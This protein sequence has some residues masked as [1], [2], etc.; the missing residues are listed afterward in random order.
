MEKRQ[1]PNLQGLNADPSQFRN[2]DFLTQQ[3]MITNTQGTPMVDPP[4]VDQLPDLDLEKNG[5]PNAA[6]RND[7][8]AKIDNQMKP[9]KAAEA[10]RQIDRELS[11]L[12]NKIPGSQKDPK[13]ILK[14]LI[15]KGTYEETFELL[16]QE[17]TMRAL[18]QND[19]LLAADEIKDD[20]E[21]QAG[22]LSAVMFSQVIFS[23]TALNKI[24]LGKW[25]PE[26]R[27]EDFNMNEIAYNMAIRR[28]LMTYMGKLSPK[29]IDDLYMKYIEINDK[30]NEAIEELKNS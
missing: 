9:D 24:P 2:T 8:K 6:T 5:L 25:F 18:D 27:L 14:D 12:T 29:I 4:M 20:V 15:A 3:D 28:A 10:Q 13:N 1:A 16:G 26:I 22:R 17:W 30:R 19:T 23:I 21:T 11:Q 7:I